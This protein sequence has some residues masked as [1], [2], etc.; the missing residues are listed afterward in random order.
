[1]K[2][3]FAFDKL[4]TN[5][6]CETLGGI[7][8]FFAMAYIVIVNPA[9][10]EN[11]GIPREASITATIIA[12]IVGTLLMAFYARRPF[13]IA[14]YM[15][16]NA[17]IA[18]TVCLGMGYP[19]EKALGAV[20][21]G[22][23]VF[24]IITA[25]K[26]RSWIARAIP[27]CLKRSFAVGIGF[28]IMFIGFNETGLIR[29]GI[30]GAPVKI[31]LLSSTGP[32]LAIVCVVLICILMILKTPGAILIGI[33]A[34]TILAYIF[35]AAELPSQLFSMPPSLK[36]ILFKLDIKGALSI[37]FWSVIVV[38]FILDFVDT[39]G[40]LIGVS[41][42][43]NLLDDEYNL[44]DI[45][46][47]MMADA[48][49]TVVGS[50]VGTSTTGTYIESSAGIEAGAKTGFASLVTAIMFV[51]CLF[52][53]PVLVSVPPAAYGSALIV[54]GFLMLSPIKEIHFNDY[55][56]LFPSVVTIALMSFTYNIGLGMAA[57]FF[58]YP[59][60][61]VISGKS[62]ELSAGVWLMFIISIMLFV[63]YPYDK[64]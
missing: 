17:F 27:V 23:V 26:I 40:T 30:E 1:M 12:A 52:I 62:R 49:A 53:A 42:R 5:Y 31:G 10:L 11:A 20:F 41:A 44:P 51:L 14:P 63:F 15:G 4:G 16:E 60:L 24:V 8:T 29:L 45:E 2:K 33:I 19:W 39:M 47:P 61:K 28:F 43:A 21:I 36:P 56:E 48:I 7:T 54:V 22:G 55:S 59:I 18:F 50:L 64:L 35:G 32:I 46:K 3:F 25:L 38:V 9:I 37:D 6:H 58:L 57:G 34:T 13:A